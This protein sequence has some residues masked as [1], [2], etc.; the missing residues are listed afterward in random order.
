MGPVR[1]H[2]ASPTSSSYHFPFR[3]LC[4]LTWDL[5][6]HQLPPASPRQLSLCAQ[7][8][9][10]VTVMRPQEH[11]GYLVSLGQGGCLQTPFSKH[12]TPFPLCSQKQ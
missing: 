6:R 5:S 3:V 2:R 4:S 8:S 12:H 1:A 7:Q 11:P 9:I 10:Q